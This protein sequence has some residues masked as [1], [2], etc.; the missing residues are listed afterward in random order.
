MRDWLNRHSVGFRDSQI[1]VSN[2]SN[3]SDKVIKK[4]I[5]LFAKLCWQGPTLICVSCNKCIYRKSV[6]VFDPSKY[7]FDVEE[8]IYL[9][10]NRNR[11]VCLTRDK[12]LK[13]QKI[14]K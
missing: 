11:V 3:N 6:K 10:G 2:C 14:L 8:F 13:K 4:R 5:E 12:Y 1:Q 7:Y 9:L